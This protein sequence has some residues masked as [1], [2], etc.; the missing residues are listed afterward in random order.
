MTPLGRA[1][2]LVDWDLRFQ[3]WSKSYFNQP[4]ITAIRL[5]WRLLAKSHRTR[6]DW[7]ALRAFVNAKGNSECYTELN[8]PNRSARSDLRSQLKVA[9]RGDDE[10]MADGWRFSFRALETACLQ[11]SGLELAWFDWQLLLRLIRL[12][13][14]EVIIFS[15]K[16]A[17]L[18][19]SR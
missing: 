7:R 4:Y 17:V 6:Q 12:P 13:F 3:S 9:A 16:N 8:D 19:K 11:P 15:L 10:A 1:K 5:R 14:Q 2:K 18:R